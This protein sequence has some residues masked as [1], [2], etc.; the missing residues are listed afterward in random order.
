LYDRLAQ[1]KLQETLI[2]L[3]QDS[4]SKRWKRTGDF[5]TAVD[6]DSALLQLPKEEKIPLDAD[7]SMIVKFDGRN[8]RGY[9]SARDKLRQFEQDAPS[10]VAARF[11]M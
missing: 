7:H 10:V 1:T 8:D 5:V 3:S 4:E 9:T 2:V 6:A 11:C